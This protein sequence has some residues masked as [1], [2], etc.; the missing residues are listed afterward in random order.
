[1]DGG[2]TA[3][4]LPEFAYEF[5]TR[6]GSGD[7]VPGRKYSVALEYVEAVSLTCRFRFV[8]E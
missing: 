1:M 6:Y 5:T 8:S 2:R 7:L 3:C 4:I